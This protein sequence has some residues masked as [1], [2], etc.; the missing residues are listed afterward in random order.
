[1]S[2][3]FKS[4]IPLIFL[5]SQQNCL[6]ARISHHIQAVQW[7][8]K[9]QS[10]LISFNSLPLLQLFHHLSKQPQNSYNNVNNSHHDSFAFHLDLYT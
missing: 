1:M 2:N 8:R 10:I 6:K 4:L 3:M 7:A 5:P 9:L